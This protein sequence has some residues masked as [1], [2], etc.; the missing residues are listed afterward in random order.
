MAVH[1][2]NVQ[3][4]IWIIPPYFGGT[5]VIRSKHGKPKILSSNRFLSGLAAAYI[6]YGIQYY[7]VCMRYS[8][9]E[10]SVESEKIGNC[11][12]VVEVG[13]GGRG[14]VQC[15]KKKKL[16]DGAFL[17]RH[18]CPITLNLCKKKCF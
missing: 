4:E 6:A 12:K 7:S 8:D 1:T 9:L 10:I 3:L 11:L 16:K 13:V 15:E 14:G 5:A 17:A 2:T 18:F